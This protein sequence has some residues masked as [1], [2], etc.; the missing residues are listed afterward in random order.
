MQYF[1]K[2]AGLLL[3]VG[4]VSTHSL[5]PG[6]CAHSLFSAVEVGRYQGALHV[7]EFRFLT[8]LGYCLGCECSLH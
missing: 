6:G 2:V 4:E 3:M 5:V 8:L 1:P 7:S